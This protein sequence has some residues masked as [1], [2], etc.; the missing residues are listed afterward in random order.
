MLQKSAYG[1]EDCLLHCLFISQVFKL[2]GWLNRFEQNTRLVQ[3]T[4]IEHL[5]APVIHFMTFAPLLH[6]PV[7]FFRHDHLPLASETKQNMSVSNEN[8]VH[9][10]RYKY[11]T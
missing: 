4:R 8:I 10:H 1:A 7:A 5:L 9:V 6:C 11:L 3:S 2:T